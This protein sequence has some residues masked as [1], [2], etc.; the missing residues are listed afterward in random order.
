MSAR[1]PVPLIIPF[2]V[3]CVAVA[4][5]SAMD[6][7]MKHLAIVMGAYGAMLWRTAISLMLLGPLFAL[8]G[9]RWPRR[10]V[11][12]LHVARGIVHGVSLLLFFWALARVPMALGIALTF[13]APLLALGLAAIFLKEKVARS[14]AGASLIA[15]GGVLVILFAQPHGAAGMGD[16]RPLAALLFAAL[17]YAVGV[18]IG[19]PLAQRASPLEVALFFNIVVFAMLATVAPWLAVW[20]RT[21]D[22]PWLLAAVLTS[23][24]SIMLLAWAYARAEAQYLLPVEY[25]AFIWASLLGW[26]AFG[27]RV[28]VATI[29]GAGLIVIACLLAARSRPAAVPHPPGHTDS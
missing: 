18:V 20:P 27:E 1:P 21:V 5:F 11:L 28:T 15:F 19:R 13:V 4:I 2:A 7:A 26:L 16:W 17:L 12:A 14:A 29:G 8:R 23:S 6:A 3:A 22:L 10:P 9:G 24:G 25:T